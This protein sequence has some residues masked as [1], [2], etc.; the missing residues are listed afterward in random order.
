[1][2]KIGPRE[3]PEGQ[4]GWFFST[5]AHASFPPLFVG[6]PG[7]ALIGLQPLPNALTTWL[8]IA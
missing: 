3:Q 4:K 7:T 2:G 1:V 5:W 6:V 8:K